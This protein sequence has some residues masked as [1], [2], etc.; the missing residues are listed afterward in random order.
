MEKYT[1]I[2]NEMAE[3]LNGEKII[4]DEESWSYNSIELT[5]NGGKNVVRSAKVNDY[6][7]S[8][9]LEV[10]S[11]G[12]YW[13]E[14]WKTFILTPTLLANFFNADEVYWL[15]HDIWWDIPY[16][17]EDDECEREFFQLMERVGIDYKKYLEE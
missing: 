3:L 8:L 2:L 1:T 4:F 6:P 7:L 11:S 9:V 16:E 15:L 13:G 17:W 12:S 14:E 10:Q 5:F